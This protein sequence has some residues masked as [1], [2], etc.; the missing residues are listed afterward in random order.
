[1]A[2]ALSLFFLVTFA[3]SWGIGEFWFRLGPDLYLPLP[4][5][6]PLYMCGPALGAVVAV[7]FG[8]GERL[9]WLGPLLRPSAWL[10]LAA[11]APFGFVILHM[12]IVLLFPGVSLVTD[13]AGLATNLEALAPPAGA[14][15]VERELA[16]AGDALLILTLVQFVIA[17]LLAGATINAVIAFG[18]ELGWRG[19]LHRALAP[20]GFWR[21][22]ALVG[23]VW[24][25]WHAP[26]IVRG[27]NYPEHPEWGVGL[28]VLFCLLLAAPL[29]HLRERAGSV[30]APALAHGVLNGTGGTLIFLTGAGDLVRGPAGAAGLLALLVFNAL[31]WWQRRP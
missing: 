11:L 10:W 8:L 31:V 6:A 15:L 14:A 12:A 7:R 18:E 25:V 24:G 2:R 23:V 17:G 28:M 21:R 3:W 19:F 29:D 13:S 20:L 22:A 9:A 4:L 26:L 30:Y 27:H 16:E 1:M 5:L